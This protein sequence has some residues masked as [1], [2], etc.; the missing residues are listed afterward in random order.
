M[1]AEAA[2]EPPDV[3]TASE[4]YAR[5]FAGR[6]GAWFLEVQA[7]TTLE[8]LR[9]WPFA[10]VLEVGGG[11]GQLTGALVEAGHEVTVYGSPG[12]RGERL[13][14]WADSG[15]VRV[16]HGDLLRAPWPDRA[17]DVVL[18]FRLLAHVPRWRELVAELG[19]LSAGAL[20][21]DYPTTRSLNAVAGRLFALKKAIEGDTRTFTVFDDGDVGEA[22]LAQGLRVTARRPQFFFPMALHRA[23]RLASVARSLEAG[24]RAAGLTRAW[25]SPVIVRAERDVR[26]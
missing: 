16:Q 11:H 19:R 13:R 26:P 23:L 20:V 4:R 22:L 21:V 3:E 10:R 2:L 8:L 18:S 7:R 9:P 14:P 24:A 25:G 1:A 12:A 17:F 15:R 5:R 6:V